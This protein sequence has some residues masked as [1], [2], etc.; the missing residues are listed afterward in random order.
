[1][2]KFLVTLLAAVMLISAM[3]V[4]AFAATV[5]TT[6]S[7]TSKDIT[8]KYA[9]GTK[10]D[11]YKVKLVWGSMEFTWSTPTQE[12]DVDTMTWKDVEGA[13]AGWTYEDRAN[14]VEVWNYSSQSVDVQFSYTPGENA[15]G[16]TGV[17][18]VD[19]TYK[20]D[21]LNQS[22]EV[23]YAAA[24]TG[25]NNGAPWVIAFEVTLNGTYTGTNT[26][27]A[28]VGTLTVTIS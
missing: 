13:E 22:Y 3:S 9:E 16:V 2:K 4:S 10:T 12:W 5:D 28:A 24:G 23:R 26:T 20:K 11:A 6:G 8:A 25:E 27:A 19:E 17:N 14:V 15:N 1:M 7:D 18:V 21:A